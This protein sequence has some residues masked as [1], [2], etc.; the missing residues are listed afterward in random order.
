MEIDKTVKVKDEDRTDYW[1]H[2]QCGVGYQGFKKQIACWS[3][4]RGFIL[5]FEDLGRLEDIE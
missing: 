4:I 3:C 1:H 2:C 5:S